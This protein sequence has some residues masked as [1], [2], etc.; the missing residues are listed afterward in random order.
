MVLCVCVCFFLHKYT[1][2]H[3]FYNLRTVFFN[4]CVNLQIMMLYTKECCESL[5]NKLPKLPIS[6][7]WKR[8]LYMQS[9]ALKPFSVIKLSFAEFRL[10]QEHSKICFIEPVKM[11]HQT[12]NQWK[13]ILP[14]LPWCFKLLPN[15]RHCVYHFLLTWASWSTNRDQTRHEKGNLFKL[16][17]SAALIS[18]CFFPT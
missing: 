4:N 14:Y 13:H 6:V 10:T 8:K 5:V 9:A 3:S 1:L 12:L 16:S 2:Q 17:A 11:N 7:L 18:M 15:E